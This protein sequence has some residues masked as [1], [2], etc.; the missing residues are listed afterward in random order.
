ML[1]INKAPRGRLYALEEYSGGFRGTTEKDSYFRR[2]P[3]FYL[4]CVH[5]ILNTIKTITISI[6]STES[7]I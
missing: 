4:Y 6:Y 5:N 3:S 1:G 2:V 7:M